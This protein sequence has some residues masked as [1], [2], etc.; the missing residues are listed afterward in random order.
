VSRSDRRR[1]RRLRLLAVAASLPLT[2]LLL[3]VVEL[4]LRPYASL[5][6]RTTLFVRDPELGWR[7]RPGAEHAWG[8]VPIRIN[9]KGL[10]GPERPYAKP[11]G[12]RRILFLGDS[13]TFGFRLAHD[14]ETFPQRVEALCNANRPATVEVVNAGVDG[15]SPWQELAYLRSE[16]LHYEPDLIVVS[17]ILND[18]TEKLALR[19]FGGW[20]EGFQLSQAA[21]SWREWLADHTAIGFFLARAATRFRFGEDAAAAARA[22]EFLRIEALVEEPENPEIRHAWD[23][24]LS[25]LA[26]IVDI[27]KKHD[28]GLLLVAFPYTFQFADPAARAQPQH[29]LERFA[30]ERGVPFLDLLPPLAERLQRDNLRPS[31]VFLDEDHLSPRGAEIVAELIVERIRSQQLLPKD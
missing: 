17:F 18:V 1:E 3:I 15:Y 7:M 25:N 23:I 8:G 5:G 16:G 30:A 22:A 20:S 10:R 24:T 14:E 26:G 12:V 27:A 2:V 11:A 29:I 31:D 28:V 13:V 9:D 6:H 4:A 21:A 19:R